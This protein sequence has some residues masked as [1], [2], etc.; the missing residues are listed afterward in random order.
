MAILRGMETAPPVF[1]DDPFAKEMIDICGNL[2]SWSTQVRH[3][4]GNSPL[5]SLLDP[6]VPN[7]IYEW[8]QSCVALEHLDT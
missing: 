6:K 2:G 8:F 1:L 5:C 3:W 7:M 4:G